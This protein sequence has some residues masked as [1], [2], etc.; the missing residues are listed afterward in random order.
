MLECWND[1]IKKT[2]REHR[3][4]RLPS[5]P[6]L[7]YSITPIFMDMTMLAGKTMHVF[8]SLM[9]LIYPPRCPICRKFLQQ[10]NDRHG[11][12]FC[13]TCFEGFTEITAPVCPTCGRPFLTTEG[14]DH[15]CEACLRKRPFYDIARAPYLYD[16]PL[17]SAIHA[18]KYSGKSRLAH[19]LG[20]LLSSFAKPWLEAMTDL[21]VMPVPLHPRRLWE[22]GFNQSLLLARHVVSGLGSDLDFLSLRR[23][24][25]TRPQTGLKSEERRKNVRGAF[26]VR[27]RSAVSRRTVVLVDD[28][29][30][31]GNTLNDCARAL[32]KAGARDVYGLVLA[33]TRTG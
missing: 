3:V 10:A 15:H 4:P 6:I 2:A 25:D 18:F 29:A 23:V 5:T 26:D 24:R 7:Q 14:G 32:K 1:G 16:G 19:P 20:V 13:K 21:L 31:T 12:G 33:R 8:K 30:T 22:R 28:V 27:D 9:D 11:F 17:M